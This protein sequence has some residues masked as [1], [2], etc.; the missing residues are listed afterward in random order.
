MKPL[1]IKVLICPTVRDLDMDLICIIMV[2]LLFR[3]LTSSN[4]S[5]QLKTNTT[6]GATP[7]KSAGKAEAAATV[8]KPAATAAAAAAPVD[9]GAAFKQYQKLDDLDIIPNLDGFECAIC[10][11]DFEPGEG[12]VLRECLHTFCK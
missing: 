7:I 10:F 12:V 11:L 4:P 5:L 8:A 6:A 3:T 1:H 9:P 2:G